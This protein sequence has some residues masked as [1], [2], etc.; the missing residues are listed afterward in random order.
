M[1]GESE[2]VRS[3]FRNFVQTVRNRTDLRLGLISRKYVNEFR[4]SFDTHVSLTE[5]L[6]AQE[7]SLGGHRQL[8][9]VVGS[10]DALLVTAAALCNSGP[11]APPYCFSEPFFFFYSI[12]NYYY[13][14][15]NWNGNKLYN[16]AFDSFNDFF[17]TGSKKVFVFV[18]DDDSLQLS[19]T[20]FSTF[21]HQVFPNEPMTVFG[22]V[23]KSL[24][25]SPCHAKTTIDKQTI[26][27]TGA[28]YMTLIG[29]TSGSAFN[30]CDS[31]WS[32]HFAQLSESVVSLAND[33]F[34]LT[35]VFPIE[36]T[37]FKVNGQILSPS[38]YSLTSNKVKI[39][40]PSILAL[41]QTYTLSIRYTYRP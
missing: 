22:F 4:L 34:L 21:Y 16:K 28:Q 10:H 23:A 31:N 11:S 33:T 5:S 6:T 41:I 8:D 24:T 12:E 39:L 38:Q 27:S 15:S 32:N 26:S 25:E 3:N 7:M 29:S 40:D 30:V 36:V 18:T 9:W 35:Q 20:Q 37:E 14:F 2:Q 19:A 13:P 17:R 1:V